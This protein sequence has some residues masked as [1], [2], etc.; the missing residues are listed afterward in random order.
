MSWQRRTKEEGKK[1]V[2]ARLA[3]ASE[4]DPRLLAALGLGREFF[5]KFQQ[6]NVDQNTLLEEFRDRCPPLTAESLDA[7]F[8]TRAALRPIDNPIS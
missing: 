3:K 5:S 4:S 6:E 8:T 2:M 1:A 7:I